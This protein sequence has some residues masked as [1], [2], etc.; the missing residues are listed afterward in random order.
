MLGTEVFGGREPN[1]SDPSNV[2]ARVSK[3]RFGTFRQVI[4]AW[5]AAVFRSLVC[6]TAAALRVT[7]C[8]VH[9]KLQAYQCECNAINVAR[10]RQHKTTVLADR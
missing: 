2:L 6:R 4:A 10:A 1:T 8:T 3:N 5:P 9:A 7:H